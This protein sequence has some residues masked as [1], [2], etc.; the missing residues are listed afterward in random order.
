MR[1]KVIKPKVGRPGRTRDSANILI[2]NLRDKIRWMENNEYPTFYNK[3]P[4]YYFAFSG[5]LI[6]NKF[7]QYNNIN[8]LSLE[9]LIVLSYYKYLFRADLKHWGLYLTK[10]VFALNVLIEQK[11]VTYIEVPGKGRGLVKKA[12]TL[13]QLGKDIE[14]SFEKYY[15]QVITELITKKNAEKP[16]TFSRFKDGQPFTKNRRRRRGRDLKFHK[17][18]DD[19]ETKST[20]SE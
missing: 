19:G 1:K 2:H 15:E 5:Y 11:Y 12:L 16:N 14:T 18:K 13:T 3:K 9:I 4:D 8:R 10:Y 7:I 20:E 17:K 6:I